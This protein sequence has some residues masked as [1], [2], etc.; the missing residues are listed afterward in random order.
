M[1]E[2][3]APADSRR[4]SAAGTGFPDSSSSRVCS[5]VGVVWNPGCLWAD[6]RVPLG[7]QAPAPAAGAHG[8]EPQEAWPHVLPLP[9]ARPGGFP[10]L[11]RL[12]PLSVRVSPLV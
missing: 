6:L 9:L 12:K 2:P 3:A 1:R 4:L 5:Y 10:R 8:P 7:V 11:S